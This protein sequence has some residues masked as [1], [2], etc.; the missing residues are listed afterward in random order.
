MAY[1]QVVVFFSRPTKQEHSVVACIT[2]KDHYC[3]CL[4]V[5]DIT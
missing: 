2:I 1:R 5:I 3:L 4:I